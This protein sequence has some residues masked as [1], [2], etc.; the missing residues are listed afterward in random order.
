MNELKFS[1][2][3]VLIFIKASCSREIYMVASVHLCVS[4]G[5]I[6]YSMGGANKGGI[7]NL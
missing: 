3:R 4:E 1:F 7:K 6:I 5:V 2:N